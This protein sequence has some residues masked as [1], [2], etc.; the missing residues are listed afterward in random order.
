M[1]TKKGY[2][3]LV[4]VSGLAFNTPATEPHKVAKLVLA[5]S[6]STPAFDLDSFSINLNGFLKEK[7]K[8]VK[9]N[10]FDKSRIEDQLKGDKDTIVQKLWMD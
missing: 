3:N 9:V 6:E 2:D 1:T 7:Y 4:E 5:I 10:S 8:G